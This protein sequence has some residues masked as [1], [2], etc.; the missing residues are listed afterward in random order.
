MGNPNKA[1]TFDEE[2]SRLRHSWHAST[3]VPADCHS[4]DT[5]NACNVTGATYYFADQAW[6]ISHGT[7]GR[8]WLLSPIV[9]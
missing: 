4:R 1:M 7:E 8:G 6:K 9:H 3:G 2:S 5:L